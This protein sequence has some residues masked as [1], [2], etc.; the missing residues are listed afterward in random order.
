LKL[1]LPSVPFQREQM[2]T[3]SAR[4]HAIAFVSDLAAGSRMITPDLGTRRRR[5][6][7]TV[8]RPVLEEDWHLSPGTGPAS[9]AAWSAC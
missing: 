2:R 1:W 3:C 4:S 9:P 6:A 8:H 7:R 5:S